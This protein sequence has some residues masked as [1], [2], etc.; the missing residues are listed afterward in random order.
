MAKRVPSRHEGLFAKNKGPLRIGIFGGTFD[1]VHLGHLNLAR[2]VE[3]KL[4]L[5]RVLFVPAFLPPHKKEQWQKIEKPSLRLK[6]LRIALDSD[7]T[8]QICHYELKKKRPVRTY[9]TVQALKKRYRKGTEFFVITGSDNL[10][11][12]SQWKSVKKIM[13]IATFVFATRPGH[14][15]IQSDEGSISLDIPPMDISSSAIRDRIAKGKDVSKFLPDAVWE[16]IKL[17][18][19]YGVAR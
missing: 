3:K 15:N 6:L 19:A 14:S 11:T 4:H 10:T 5:D 17:T 1:P 13:A 7:S 9:E 12:L 18:G 8:F 2:Q 16:L